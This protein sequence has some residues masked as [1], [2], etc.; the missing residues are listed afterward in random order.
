MVQNFPAPP[1]F[2]ANAPDGFLRLDRPLPGKSGVL[3]DERAIEALNE[4]RKQHGF[5]PRTY[6]PAQAR[7][8]M[9]AATVQEAYTQHLRSTRQLGDRFPVREVGA[10]GEVVPG[11]IA[12]FTTQQILFIEDVFAQFAILDVVSVFQATGPSVRVSI[13][14]LIRGDDC[15]TF[16]SANDPLVDGLDPTCVECP[17]DCASGYHIAVDVDG[18]TLTMECLRVAGAE[19]WPAALHHDSQYPGTLEAVLKAGFQIELQRA[20]QARTL[21]NMV[22]AAG[23]TTTW[24]QTVPA[25]GYFATANPREWRQELAR[26][27]NI[28]NRAML[29][30]TDG[31]VNATH[32]IGGVDAIGHLD[33]AVPFELAGMSDMQ[34][35]QID[36]FGAFLG[37][38][39]GR[40]WQ[41]FQFLEGM[42]DD[43]LLL[44]NK[45]DA[46]PSFA[47]FPWVMMQDFGRLT[48]PQTGETGYGM[49]HLSVDYAARPGRIQE[50]QIG[51]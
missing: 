37:M 33:D 51:A 7:R 14:Q 31:R 18:V 17:T 45:N 22:A 27:V 20:I 30:A 23:G 41:V 34:T 43:T 10:G 47:F 13:R 39:K 2:A 26:T 4:L 48:D 36:Q 6:T 12:N 28:Q 35:S 8:I 25:V 42:P 5:A 15:G 16:Y 29:N 50:I 46:Q 40:R 9:A 49:G 44:I 3:A 38:S 32:V 21:T 1:A 24:N 11:D 19:C